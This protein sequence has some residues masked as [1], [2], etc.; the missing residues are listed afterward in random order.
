MRLKLG[1]DSYSY[2][3]AF[4][5]HPDFK[6]RRPLSL[7]AF[8]ERVAQLRLDGFQIDP[9]HLKSWDRHY[10]ATVRAA[11]EAQGLFLEFG[12]IGTEPR[13]LARDLRIAAHLGSAVLRTFVGC[14]RY[15]RRSDL[16]AE[17][18]RA[19][20][21][22]KAVRSLATDLGVR[23]AVENHGD[24][25]T[26]ELLEVVRRV[27]SP[28]VGV[29]LDVGNPLLTGEDPLA[30]TRKLAPYA[31]TTHF[32][33]YTFQPTNYGAKIAGVALGQG[34]IDL[35]AVLRILRKAARLDRIVLEIPVEAQG[36][37]RTALGHEERCVQQ[38]VAYARRVLG[39]GRA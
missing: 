23:L 16:K 21:G 35:P 13:R 38:S 15:D 34:V 18:R 10:L 12:A 37:E 14:N 1:L 39:L 11:A 28:A 29:C 30:A 5:A 33:D 20:A 9:L 31:V 3:L 22:L 26:D 24:L 25:K 32:K 2:H 8:I 36:A 27:D 4:G 7:L 19:V 17:I 6:P